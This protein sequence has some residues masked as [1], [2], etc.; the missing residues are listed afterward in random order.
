M[1]FAPAPVGALLEIGRDTSGLIP[2]ELISAAYR[3][4]RA[5]TV[6]LVLDAVS[7]REVDAIL[8]PMIGDTYREH[9]GVIY[10]KSTDERA[11]LSGAATAKHVFAA[12]AGFRAKLAAWGIPFEDVSCAAPLL[13]EDAA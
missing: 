3:A 13:V 8:D 10:A 4:S 9:C 7:P 11:V 12:S 5:Q 2:R 1:P 6:M